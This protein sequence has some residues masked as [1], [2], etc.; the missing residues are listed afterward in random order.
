M[1]SVYLRIKF[2]SNCIA[3][4]CV[5]CVGCVVC[6]VCGVCGVWGVCVCVVCVC[7][8]MCVHAHKR[9]HNFEPFSGLSRAL[10][11]CNSI[12]HLPNVANSNF[13]QLTSPICLMNEF[14]RS[15][16]Q[17]MLSDLRKYKCGGNANFLFSFQ[18]G[19]DN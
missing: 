19:V 7:V 4:W 17:G 9:V 13:I 3:Y 14:T 2:W 10:F 12:V 8:C 16:R 1:F 5:W 18:I 6:V 15:L 11:G